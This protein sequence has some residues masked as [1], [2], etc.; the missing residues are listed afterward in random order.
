MLQHLTCILNRTLKIC[1]LGLHLKQESALTILTINR[2]SKDRNYNLVE[3]ILSLR[4]SNYQEEQRS[5]KSS[6]IWP[7]LRHLFTEVTLVM[8]DMVSNKS[9]VMVMD[10]SI[11]QDSILEKECSLACNKIHLV[12]NKSLFRQ[13]SI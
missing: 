8:Q 10:K 3:L 5:D 9:L 7:S 4:V 2:D 11:F 13:I 6:K 1:N 12:H